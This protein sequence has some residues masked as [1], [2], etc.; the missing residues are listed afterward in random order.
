MTIACTLI[1]PHNSTH[2]KSQRQLCVA[3]IGGDSSLL[4]DSSAAGPSAAPY[5]KY[6]VN[7]HQ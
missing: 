5:V 1:I 7:L 6:S 3:F 2:L 4:R